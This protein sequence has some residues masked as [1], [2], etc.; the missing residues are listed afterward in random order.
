MKRR[1]SI[2]IVGAA[3][4]AL[5]T[6][7]ITG[8][9]A[10]TKART[11]SSL[12]TLSIT[13]NGK[14][15]TVTPTIQSGAVN[16]VTTVNGERQGDPSLIRLNPG[17]SFSVFG[18]AVQAVNKHHGDLNYLRPYGSL[19][20]DQAVNKGTGSAQTTL[21][22]GNY[23]A[24]DTAPRTPAHA[25]FTV[26]QATSPA[27]LPKPAG[28]VSAIE[29][30]FTGPSTWHTGSLV[31]FEDD[32]FLVHMIVGLGVK[33]AAAAKQLMSALRA[34]KDHAA[35]RLVTSEPT[36]GAGPL[37]P[38]GM[39]QEVIT[40]KPGVYVIACFMDTQDGREHTQLGMERMIK[41]VK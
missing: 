24:L 19:V 39:Q 20:F 34:G 25:E 32:G 9:A 16:V 7:A 38:G 30:G 31:R 22:P 35:Q 21:E 11:A 18:Q 12:P 10:A 17:V 28:T 3:I 26:T 4:A 36:F 1:A 8:V 15:V 27:A 37:S 29:F 41:V 13:T 33:N 6:F 5:S 14:A 23:F 40:A 2:V